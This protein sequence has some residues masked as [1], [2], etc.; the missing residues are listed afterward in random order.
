MGRDELAFVDFASVQLPHDRWLALK[1]LV[2]DVYVLK[3][4]KAEV[5]DLVGKVD[6]HS[7]HYQPLIGGRIMV[8]R[9]MEVS[10]H[11][12]DEHEA[13]ELAAFPGLKSVKCVLINFIDDFAGAAGV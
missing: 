7:A 4:A 11:F 10:G 2:Y 6:F 3:V 9:D 13:T 12:V 5:I 8:H 1:F